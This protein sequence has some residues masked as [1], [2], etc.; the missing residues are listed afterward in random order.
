MAFTEL[1][2]AEIGTRYPQTGEAYAQQLWSAHNGHLDERAFGT[3]TRSKV[4]LGLYRRTR[5]LGFTVAAEKDGQRVKFG[6]SIV[7]PQHRNSQYAV[8]MRVVAEEIFRRRGAALA[9]STCQAINAP[10][11]RYVM[12]A[13]YRL[14]ASLRDHYAPGSTELVFTKQ[15][16]GDRPCALDAPSDV[17]A[18]P[19]RG[20][21]MK[22][23]LPFSA[24]TAE[25]MSSEHFLES[26]LRTARLRAAARKLYA[27]TPADSWLAAIAT[28]FGFV[29]EA[30]RGRGPRLPPLVL[31]SRFVS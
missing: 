13:G 31:F 1:V 27:W 8:V 25:G 10:A 2:A 21:S 16:A 29:S 20:G 11:R 23:H 30:Q 24:P 22:L 28:R 15:L 9:Y 7:L 4:I 18:T 12:R 17:S 19:K 5:L 14:A 6:P 3:S 26:M